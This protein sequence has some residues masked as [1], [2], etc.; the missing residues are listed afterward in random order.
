MHARPLHP[1]APLIGAQSHQQN[2]THLA[3][4][5]RLI[6]SRHSPRRSSSRKANL[7]DTKAF[8]PPVSREELVTQIYCVDYRR[9]RALVASAR[10][11]LAEGHAT[12]SRIQDHCGQVS[13]Y[14]TVDSLPTW[15]PA[16]P[17]TGC[18]KPWT[19]FRRRIMA[20]G[21]YPDAQVATKRQRQHHS[22]S[23]VCTHPEVAVIYTA[24]DHRAAF[25]PSR[26]WLVHPED[27]QHHPPV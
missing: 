10:Q 11:A 22:S 9:P 2:S 25:R 16:R 26:S 24:T 6:C 12:P 20:L 7:L 21:A 19:V 5:I 4:K 14:P 23:I 27:P 13:S 8:L 18:L 3:P 17:S 15:H 1:S